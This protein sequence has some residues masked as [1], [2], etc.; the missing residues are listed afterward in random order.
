MD[1][2]IVFDVLRWTLSMY[3]YYTK[4]P[5]SK[6]TYNNKQI[7]CFTC[8]IIRF[9]D[10]SKRKGRLRTKRQRIFLYLICTCLCFQPI[11][12]IHQHWPKSD[13]SVSHWHIYIECTES[14]FTDTVL[15]FQVNYII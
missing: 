10:N 7:L 12:Y 8:L 15:T 9:S 14:H 1:I 11:C 13:V 3:L 6:P 2:L 5:G 4:E